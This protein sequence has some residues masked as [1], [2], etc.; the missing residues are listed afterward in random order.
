[1]FKNY[2]SHK[3]KR[4]GWRNVIETHR[5][6]EEFMWWRTSRACCIIAVLISFNAIA[7]EFYSS[8]HAAL[9]LLITVAL[10]ISWV[11][12]SIYFLLQNSKVKCKF[13]STTKDEAEQF[14][15]EMCAKHSLPSDSHEVVLDDGWYMV[16]LKK[17][18]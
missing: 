14:V 6:A 5:K 13:C 7:Y 10:C 1:M 4:Y 18:R 2:F 16:F 9:S 15:A 12:Y 3:G 11:T 17:E 8:T